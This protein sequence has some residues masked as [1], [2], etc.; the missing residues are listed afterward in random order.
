VTDRRHI[1]AVSKSCSRASASF[2]ERHLRAGRSRLRPRHDGVF[3]DHACAGGYGRVGT[4]PAHSR[5]SSFRHWATFVLGALLLVATGDSSASSRPRRV[6]VSR[7]PWVGCCVRRVS[8]VEFPA[9]RFHQGV[10][11][12]ASGLTT[13]GGPV[14]SGSNTFPARIKN[15]GVIYQLAGGHGH[16]VLAVGSFPC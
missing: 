3:R 4:R 12:A 15:C 9:D 14:L 13:T 16:L 6:D 7:A 2:C 10:I 1:E 11:E 8:A 5:R